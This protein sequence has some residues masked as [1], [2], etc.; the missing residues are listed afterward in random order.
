MA[1]RSRHPVPA[2]TG[3]G[4]R[5]PHHAAVRETR[6]T[7]GWLEVHTENYL[8]GGKP[9]AHLEAIRAEYPIS[10]H[11]VGLSLG[12]AEGLDPRHLARVARLAERIEPA[13]V[14]EH[15][16][17]S[18]CDGKYFGELLPL[19]LT[20]ETLDVMCRNVEAM[21]EALGRTVLVENP[22]SCLRFTHSHIPEWEF[23]SALAQRTGCGLLC[24]VNNIFVSAHNLGFDP[25]AYLAG[26]PAARVREIHVAG[27]HRR[28]L[29][30]GRAILIDD[31]GS[32]V[33]DEVWR[34]YDAAIA[35]HGRV[36]TLV[37]WDTN[38][39]VLSV[40]LEEAAKA[41]AILDLHAQHVLAA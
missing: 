28:E 23:L 22:A 15:L 35:L 3:I 29:D 16:A 6:P 18:V 20:D 4:L 31:H 33:C 17:W 9:L 1:D 8:G 10:L 26:L 12:S 21:Q 37:E 40:L 41:D 38:V 13:M 32:R 14:S 2:S 30:D 5:F 39:P 11:G 27:H 25:L 19:P 34:L 7:V 24:D 36:P